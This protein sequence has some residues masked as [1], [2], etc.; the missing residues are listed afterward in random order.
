MKTKNL[1][2]IL[3]GALLASC[4]NFQELANKER[5]LWKGRSDV[6]LMKSKGVPTKTVDHSGGGKVFVYDQSRSVQMPG[7]ANTTTTPN[8]YGGG[9]TSTTSFTP[10]ANIRIRRVWEY[11][12][13]KDGKIE[14]VIIEHN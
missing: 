14:D 2:T 5:A 4:V 13:G 9:A 1:L 7:S 6:E 3:T 10:G 12:I 11:W 8:F